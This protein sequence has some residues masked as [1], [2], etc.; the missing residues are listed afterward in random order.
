LCI[1]RISTRIDGASR[2]SVRVAVAPSPPRHVEIHH[3]DVRV[4]ALRERDRLVSRRRLADDD[5]VGR[6]AEQ[7]L[8]SLSQQLVV[9]GEE[10]AYRVAGW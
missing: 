3:H 9:I 10:D 4:L 5:D 7:C 8:H 1:V 2:A 6:V